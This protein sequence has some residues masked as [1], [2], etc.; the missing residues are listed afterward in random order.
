[1]R[2]KGTEVEKTKKYKQSNIVAVPRAL[3]RAQ[4]KVVLCIDMF[5]VN[6]YVFITTYSNGICYTTT[7]HVS[8]KAVK[9]YWPYLMQ[10]I[11]MYIARGFCIIMI[12]GDF[13]FNRI[14]QQVAML[15]SAPRLDLESRT[16]KREGLLS[17][18]KPSI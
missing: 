12:R 16:Y 1:M 14:V 8:T 4:S 9:H 11:Q 5:F 13:E 15:P 17:M 10:V 3:I 2:C 18:C 7:S 6:K